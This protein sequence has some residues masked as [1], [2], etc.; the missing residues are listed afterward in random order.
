MSNPYSINAEFGE[1]IGENIGL[2]VKAATQTVL[3]K[4]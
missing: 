1:N 3:V 2:I 4:P